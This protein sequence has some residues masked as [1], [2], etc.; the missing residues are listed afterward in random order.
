M[1]YALTSDKSIMILLVQI[2]SSNTAQGAIL[3]K[4]IVPWPLAPEFG[5]MHCIPS[6]YSTMH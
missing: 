5:G 2:K 1:V 4:R 6:I 3:E